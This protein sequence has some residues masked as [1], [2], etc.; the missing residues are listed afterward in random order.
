MVNSPQGNTTTVKI[1]RAKIQKTVDGTVSDLVA[2]KT[3]MVTGQKNTDGT[4]TASN[5]QI[6]PAGSPQ[7]LSPS[8]A[9]LPNRGLRRG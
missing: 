7:R 2:G 5:V 1:A 8:G 9:E 6:R 4:V 3:V